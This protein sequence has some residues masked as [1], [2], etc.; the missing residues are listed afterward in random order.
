MIPGIQLS[1]LGGILPGNTGVIVGTTILIKINVAVCGCCGIWESCHST[2]Y[3]YPCKFFI[4][5]RNNQGLEYPGYLSQANNQSIQSRHTTRIGGN[6]W[7]GWPGWWRHAGANGRRAL[8][9]HAPQ[10][11]LLRGRYLES[12]EEEDSLRGCECVFHSYQDKGLE[13]RWDT[14]SLT[15]TWR[16]YSFVKLG[17]PIIYSYNISSPSH[18][19]IYMQIFHATTQRHTSV[20]P[21]LWRAYLVAKKPSLLCRRLMCSR[22]AGTPASHSL[23]RNFCSKVSKWQ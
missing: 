8:G 5:L 22:R 23:W 1:C 13:F 4:H 11:G 2:H 10:R 20:W 16:H 18:R 3:T 12:K 21:W 17:L 6:D 19:Y 7:A 15:G 9:I 14:L